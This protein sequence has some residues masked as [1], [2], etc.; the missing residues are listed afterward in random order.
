MYFKIP[1]TEENNY[2]EVETKY[3]IGGMNYFTSREEARGYY[4]HVSPVEERRYDSGATSRIYQGFS[5]TKQLIHEVKRKS[6]KQALI[7]DEK[8]YDRIQDLVEHV[9]EK[10]DISLAQD[11]KNIYHERVELT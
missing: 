6:E 11:W 8:A 3:N 4:L 5:G 9:C 7:A 2:V 10:N 1:T